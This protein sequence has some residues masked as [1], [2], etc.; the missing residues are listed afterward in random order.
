MNIVISVILLFLVA[1][2]P[3]LIYTIVTAKAGGEPLLKSK[4]E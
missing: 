4:E 3:T 2:L 1:I